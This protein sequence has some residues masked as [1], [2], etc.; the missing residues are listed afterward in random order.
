MSV[1]FTIFSI[2]TSTRAAQ[3]VYLIRIKHTLTVKSPSSI[4]NLQKYHFSLGIL[5][6][7]SFITL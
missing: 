1:T 7:S 4:E 3:D 5:L 2:K 6:K